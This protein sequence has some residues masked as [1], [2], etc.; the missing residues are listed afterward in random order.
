MDVYWCYLMVIWCA[1]SWC[2]YCVLEIEQ[3]HCKRCDF[4]C[5]RKLFTVVIAECG[6]K[7]VRGSSLMLESVLLTS[8][9]VLYKY[10][11]TCIII[12]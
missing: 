11:C 3:C 8:V 10:Q 4:Y 6:N 7:C 2:I 1:S 5:V 9:Q 12:L